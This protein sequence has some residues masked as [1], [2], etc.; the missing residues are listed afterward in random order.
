MTL[1]IRPADLDRD[2]PELI[3]IFKSYL[4]PQF[5]GQRFEKF[6]CNG[7]DGPAR[8][9]ILRDEARDTLVGSAAAF[10][11]R[12][13]VDGKIRRGCVL[14]D[15]C[16]EEGY[17]S[18]GP[19]VRLQRACLE[20]ANASGF[21]FCYDFPSQSMMAVYQ[22]LQISQTGVFWRWAKPLRVD[23]KIESLIPSKLVARGLSAAINAALDCQVR[24]GSPAEIC[25]LQEHE[26]LCGSE[27]SRLDSELSGQAGV[28]TVRTA[29]YLNW[30]YFHHPEARYEMMSARRGGVLIAYAVFLQEGK[31]ASIV[32][33]CSVEKPAV[34][35][36]LLAGVVE[37]LRQRDVL[38]VSLNAA[39]KHPWSPIFGRAGF[40]Q[41]EQAPLIVYT[42]PQSSSIGNVALW[43]W[44]LMRG[45]RDN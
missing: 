2:R 29:E 38:S 23:H 43:N 25:E 40:R 30:R 11:R 34:V 37:L 27:F 13:Y 6:Y 7:P 36:R 15:F 21:E 35:R 4:T 32:D 1:T 14:G 24:Y 17:R 26:G 16:I 3:R 39:D 28:R 45:D 20:E 31:Y 8:A 42:G 33:L 12:L 10:P 44:Y 22:R 19:A 5:D 18:L 41:R 9:W